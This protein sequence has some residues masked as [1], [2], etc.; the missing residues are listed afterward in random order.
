MRAGV[1]RQALTSLHPRLR[2]HGACRRGYRQEQRNV[3]YIVHDV[4][5]SIT[6]YT[7]H[8]GFT[9]EAHPAPGFAIVSR[10]ALKLFLN[11]PGTGG[12]GQSMPDGRAPEPGG[13]NRIQL[14]T[15]DLDGLVEALRAAGARFRIDI[16]Q[17]NGGRQILLEDPSGNPIEL[18]EPVAR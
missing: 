13:W 3:R 4:T 8:L 7:S 16:V 12:T 10:G 5:R 14:R 17:G 18:L 1:P 6:F 9:L 15:T 11:Q 2:R